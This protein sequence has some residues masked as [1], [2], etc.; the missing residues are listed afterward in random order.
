MERTINDIVKESK[1]QGKDS[2]WVAEQEKEQE[3]KW[4][5]VSEE[6]VVWGKNVRG[7]KRHRK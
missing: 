3:P 5:V 2:Q 6:E 7:V 1:E 4:V